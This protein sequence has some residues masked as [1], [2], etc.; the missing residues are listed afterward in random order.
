VKGTYRDL[1]A[2]VRRKARRISRLIETAGPPPVAWG[3]INRNR[4][5]GRYNPV[6]IAG[7][8]AERP[9]PDRELTLAL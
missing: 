2:G 8:R 7:E 5:G 6:L 1:S 4:P 9:A 3:F